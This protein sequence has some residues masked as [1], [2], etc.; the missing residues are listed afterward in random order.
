MEVLTSLGLAQLANRNFMNLSGGES[1][2]VCIAAL[3]AQQSNCWL[4]DEPA[5]HLDPAVQETVYNDLTTAWQSGQTMIV[6]THD[7]NL[8]L[9]S[10]PT[11]LMDKVRLI[12][13]NEGALCFETSLQDCDIA[14]K[15]SILYGIPVQV[16]SINDKTQLLFGRFH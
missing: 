1:Q 10:I 4:L 8:F 9:R 5:N 12:G 7:I 15:I 14:Q 6:V 13:I 2:R 3:I 16:V 11:S